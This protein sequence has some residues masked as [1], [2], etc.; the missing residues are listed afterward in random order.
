LEITR[1]ADEDIVHV[2]LKDQPRDENRTGR[3]CATEVVC[4]SNAQHC[5]LVGRGKDAAWM[6]AVLQHGCAGLA[7]R[8]SEHR[9][10]G[11]LRLGPGGPLPGVTGQTFGGLVVKQMC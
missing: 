2:F 7:G 4:V 8:A 10:I 9:N 11:Q 3:A 6:D 1:I 5:A